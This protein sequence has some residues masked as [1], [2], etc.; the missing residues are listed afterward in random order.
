M[1]IPRTKSGRRTWNQW[2]GYQGMKVTEG[3]AP[4]PVTEADYTYFLGMDGDTMPNGAT[5]SATIE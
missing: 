3:T 1:M 2:R 4:D 5:R